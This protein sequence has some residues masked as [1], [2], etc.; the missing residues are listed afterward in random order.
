MHPAPA[1]VMKEVYTGT[2]NLA[3]PRI[4]R[5]LVFNKGDIFYSDFAYEVF[6]LY[7]FCKYYH[8]KVVSLLRPS[9]CKRKKN[10]IIFALP[11]GQGICSHLKDPPWSKLYQHRSLIVGPYRFSR[12]R[13]LIGTN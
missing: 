7:I 4:F 5:S 3:D 12:K 8:R 6:Y 11:P 10:N 9:L 13:V 2:R 1:V